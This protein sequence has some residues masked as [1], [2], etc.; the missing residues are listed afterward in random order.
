MFKAIVIGDTH[1][2][3]KTPPCRLDDYFETGLRKLK[4]CLDTAADL[5]VDAVLH[6]GDLFN[7]SRPE[8]PQTLEVQLL[9]VLRTGASIPFWIIPGNHD[10]PYHNINNIK[11]STL[12]VLQAAGKLNILNG[13]FV[14]SD[15][16][17]IY[18]HGFPYG[19]PCQAAPA[20]EE[21]KI[22]MVHEYIYE[23]TVPPFIAGF[24]VE[25]YVKMHPGWDLIL[26][27]HNHE[28]FVKKHHNTLVLNPGNVLRQSGTPH[29]LNPRICLITIDKGLEYK[30]ISIPIEAG[31]V[32]DEY[33]KIK[34]ER[35]ERINNF[36]EQIGKSEITGLNFIQNMERY[37]DLNKVE[38]P[39]K[40]KIWEIVE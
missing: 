5:K 22:A 21:F 27:G 7:R 16:E 14:F 11:T 18:L 23:H 29:E 3:T 20:G 6:V 32:T 36:I 1:L 28:S 8:Q 4:F 24:T 31:S 39:V 33:L 10:L 40:N 30:W 12:G 13:G 25:D 34:H 38:A 35:D 26:T 19:V 37:L 2:D 17:N 15:R 9:E